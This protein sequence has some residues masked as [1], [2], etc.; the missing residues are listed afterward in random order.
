MRV[1][2]TGAAGFIGST[3]AKR[4]LERGDEVVGLD[5]LNDYYD[6]TLKQARLAQLDGAAGLPLRQGSISPIARRM[7]GAVRARTFR[8]RHPPRRAGRR[9]LLAGESARLRRQ[10][11]RRLR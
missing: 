5:N 4:L 6:V 9:S 11:R 3:R 10:Q 8:A 2:V 7:D 1:L